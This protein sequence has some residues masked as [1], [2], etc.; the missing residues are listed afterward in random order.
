MLSSNEK[1]LREKFYNAV[2]ERDYKKQALIL[3]SFGDKRL[4][5]AISLDYDI[6]LYLKHH[7]F[8]KSSSLYNAALIRISKYNQSLKNWQEKSLCFVIEAAIKSRI[9]LVEQVFLESIS[10]KVS[11]DSNFL[12]LIEKDKNH[13]IK[14]RE[15]AKEGIRKLDENNPYNLMNELDAE[16]DNSNSKHKLLRA[17]I[18][19]REVKRAEQIREIYLTSTNDMKGLIKELLSE[20]ITLLSIPPCSYAILGLGSLARSEMTPYSDLEFAIIVEDQLPILME[21]GK[22]NYKI[23]G[24]KYN[25]QNKVYFRNLATL[26]HLKIINLGETSLGVIGED[27]LEI[28]YKEQFRDYDELACGFCFDGQFAR[29]CRTPLGN[30]HIFASP[31]IGTSSKENK[32]TF[33]LIGTIDEFQNFQGNKWKK[34]DK[35]LVLELANIE[36]L[37]GSKELFDKYKKKISTSSYIELR[38]QISDFLLNEDLEK[39]KSKIEGVY[40][41]K[42]YEIKKEIYRLPDRIIENLSLL[43]G[44]NNLGAWDRINRLVPAVF[45]DVAADNLKVILGISMELRL[46]VY[47]HYNKRAEKTTIIA[48]TS[49]EIDYKDITSNH[50][51]YIFSIPA[52]SNKFNLQILFRFYYTIF[53]LQ[54]EIE[55][56]KSNNQV[57]IK[58]NLY[59]N[60]LWIKSRILA[61]LLRYQE[62]IKLLELE[63]EQD[64]KFIKEEKKNKGYL[65]NWKIDDFNSK[66]GQLTNWCMM[67][68][69][70]KK[71]EH[72]KDLLFGIMNSGTM[73]I[74]P[75]NEKALLQINQVNEINSYNSAVAL[76]AKGYENFAYGNCVQALESFQH[77]LK[78]YAQLD[79]KQE[80]IEVKGNIVCLYLKQHEIT[81]S[82]EFIY[83]AK[84][85]LQETFQ[86]LS[87]LDIQNE[88]NK[89]LK[90]LLKYQNNL[91]NFC[92][93]KNHHAT[94]EELVEII[95]EEQNYYP[96]GHPTIIRMQMQL[97]LILINI[98]IKEAIKT[99]QRLLPITKKMY[100]IEAH[101]DVVNVLSSLGNIYIELQFFDLAIKNLEEAQVIS[102]K[103]LMPDLTI[104]VSRDLIR[105]ILMKGHVLLLKNE[106]KALDS[107]AIKIY[108]KA[109]FIYNKSIKKEEIK[110]TICSS[111]F[112][113][114]A[115]SAYSN[116]KLDEALNH[117]KAV[118]KIC[119]N[120]EQFK[121][122]LDQLEKIKSIEAKLLKQYAKN[123]NLNI[124]KFNMYS[125]Q[126]NIKKYFQDFF[127]EL[128]VLSTDNDG[129]WQIE[130]SESLKYKL[131]IRG[132]MLSQLKISQSLT[133]SNIA[134]TMDYNEVTKEEEPDVPKDYTYKAS[135]EKRAKA[136]EG[137]YSND[138]V[139]ILIDALLKQN[140][141]ERENS[142]SNGNQDIVKNNEENLYTMILAPILN[143]EDQNVIASL[144]SDINRAIDKK[145]QQILVAIN[146][147]NF[148]WFTAQLLITYSDVKPHVQVILHDSAHHRTSL[149]IIEKLKEFPNISFSI[150]QEEGT[151][152]KIQV[153]QNGELI[154][155]YC[156]G[157]T[158]RLIANLVTNPNERGKW[159]WNC[160]ENNDSLLRNDDRDTVQKQ[161]P[162]R[163]GRFGTPIHDIALKLPEKVS[164]ELKLIWQEIIKNLD[165]PSKLFWKE[166]CSDTYEEKANKA[167]AIRGFFKGRI[168][169]YQKY[170]SF[171]VQFFKE[172]L[173]FQDNA[174]D[175]L[176]SLTT[177]D[178]TNVNNISSSSSN[179]DIG[180]ELTTAE[181]KNTLL[182][183][184][185]PTMDNSINTESEETSNTL[186]RYIEAKNAFNKLLIKY[187]KIPKKLKSKKSNIRKKELT[188]LNENFLKLLEK[189][190][191]LQ[192]SDH[193]HLA[194]GKNKLEL[195]LF[196]LKQKLKPDLVA[197]STYLPT[198]EEV[199]TIAFDEELSDKKIDKTDELDKKESYT[200][201]SDVDKIMEYYHSL[202]SRSSTLEQKYSNYVHEENYLEQAKILIKFGDREQEKATN[203]NY[204][205]QP[206]LKYHSVAKSASL[207]NS[208]LIRINKYAQQEEYSKRVRSKISLVEQRFLEGIGIDKK[209]IQ[210]NHSS[211]LT[212]LQKSKNFLDKIRKKAKED[213]DGLDNYNPYNSMLE[214]NNIKEENAREICKEKIQGIERARSISIKNLYADITI[215]MKLFVKALFRECVAVLGDPP[216]SY[217]VLGLGSMA[218]N[219]MTPYSDL[220]WAI[221]IEDK[222]GQKYN[223]ICGRGAEESKGEKREKYEQATEQEIIAVRNEQEHNKQYFRN[224]VTLL[225]IKIINLGETPLG[226]I[227]EE[228]LEK[229]YKEKF[230]DYDE[231]ACGFCFDGQFA[232]ACRTPLG[233]LH[234]DGISSEIEPFELIGTI[235]ELSDLQE[236]EWQ[237]LQNEKSKQS[238]NNKLL[239]LELANA[240]LLH[241]S[242][243]LFNQYK[244]MISTATYFN[245]RAEIGSALLKEDIEKYRLKTV[246][247][248]REGKLYEVKKEIYRLLDRTVENLALYKKLDLK[249]LSAWD[250]I[251]NLLSFNEIASQSL[252]VAL[253]I[254]MELRLRVYQSYGK[255]EESVVI[256]SDSNNIS[257]EDEA[258][259]EF[260]ISDKGNSINIQIL[261]RYYY[262]VLPFQ[263]IIDQILQNS[264]TIEQV[265]QNLQAG[266]LRSLYNDD[267]V[268]KGFVFN[269][270]ARYQE[271]S[272]LLEEACNKTEFGIYDFQE[273]INVLGRIYKK[274]GMRKKA[275]DL[276]SKS[277]DFDM[278]NDL[279]TEISNVITSREHSTLQLITFSDIGNIYV[280]QKKY[281]EAITIYAAVLEKITDKPFERGVTLNA[282]ADVYAETGRFQHALEKYNVAL[283]TFKK[284][285][286]L[287]SEAL[288]YNAIGNLY[289]RQ[290]NF[291][292]A[293][294]NYDKALKIFDSLYKPYS[295]IYTLN[296]IGHISMKYSFS[297]ASQ[298][299][300]KALK[301]SIKY[302]LKRSEAINY[303][304]IGNLY[305]KAKDI[306]YHFTRALKHYKDALAIFKDFKFREYEAKVELAI[307][308]L[309]ANAKGQDYN[310]NEALENYEKA[311]G[312]FDEAYYQESRARTLLA[313]GDLYAN[314]K[315]QS[316]N[317][318]K[319]LENYKKAL[320]FF[321]EVYYQESRAR[322]L[323]AIGDL[324]AN[325]KGPDYFNNAL[326]NYIQSST[327]YE[328]VKSSYLYKSLDAILN[329]IKN[330][331]DKSY[332]KNI[333]YSCT[334]EKQKIY[335]NL[336]E[337]F[338]KFQLS[339]N[340]NS[341]KY[342]DVDNTVLAILI[343]IGVENEIQNWSKKIIGKLKYCN[344]K[345]SLK[346]VLHSFICTHTGNSKNPYLLFGE[347]LGLENK[348]QESIKLYI[349]ASEHSIKRAGAFPIK[350]KEIAIEYWL[351]YNEIVL[352]NLLK[353]RLNLVLQVQQREEHHAIKILKSETF[354]YSSYDGFIH[355]ELIFLVKNILVLYKEELNTKN[356]L[357]PILIPKGVLVYHWVGVI[358]SKNDNTITISY[359]DSENQQTPLIWQN[360]LLEELQKLLRKSKI[361]FRQQELEV[362]RYNNCGPELIE[363]FVY[364]LTGT[365]ATQDGA[366]YLQSLLY[367]NSLLNTEIS[368]PQIEE[369]N[370][371]ITQLSN[372]VMPLY[373][374]SNIESIPALRIK[375]SYKLSMMISDNYEL[376]SIEDKNNFDIYNSN[377]IKPGFINIP[378][379]MNNPFVLALNLQNYFASSIT[380]LK[381]SA[382]NYLNNA[383]YISVR[384]VSHITEM[385]YAFVSSLLRDGDIIHQLR[386]L[387]NNE[388]LAEFFN[389]LH[390]CTD[391]LSKIISIAKNVLPESI[392]QKNILDFSDEELEQISS[393]LTDPEQIYTVMRFKTSREIFGDINEF[394]ENILK[395]TID[396]KIQ[397]ILKRFVHSLKSI[398]VVTDIIKYITQPTNTNLISL[399][400]DVLVLSSYLLSNKYLSLTTP[401]TAIPSIWYAFQ[402]EQ[403]MS[404]GVKV[405][406]SFSNF[407]IQE[408]DVLGIYAMPLYFGLNGVTIFYDLYNQK[409][410]EAA[411][412]AAGLVMMSVVPT[413]TAITYAV[414][415]TSQNIYSLYQLHQAI[416]KET[417]EN[418]AKL[419]NYVIAT[420]SKNNDIQEF[421]W[422]KSLKKNLFS[423][424][425]C[426]AWNEAHRE[427]LGDNLPELA[428][429]ELIVNNII[430]DLSE[431]SEFVVGSSIKYNKYNNYYNL[432][433]HKPIVRDGSIFIDALDEGVDTTFDHKHKEKYKIDKMLLEKL[434]NS[435]LDNLDYSNLL[436]FKT[437]GVDA[438]QL[439]GYVIDNNGNLVGYEYAESD[440]LKICGE[441]IIINENVEEDL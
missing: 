247:N 150:S 100:G 138:D 409:Y 96:N 116:R 2:I 178:T 38:K 316:Y 69:D 337:K 330:F 221:I 341:K 199:Y 197:Q 290:N 268:I 284:F 99:Y 159:I 369:N 98:D 320:G 334:E 282:I 214:L 35:L 204:K 427:S 183:R 385:K 386:I 345:F 48:P 411:L 12:E 203:L 262:T 190:N 404:A 16:N 430:R 391:D 11:G 273:V 381:I 439:H 13:L 8:V 289:A 186:N 425:V 139:M 194:I 66:I 313:I 317:F 25:K 32:E 414:I 305:A 60:S 140:G 78:I 83:R 44:Y 257:F 147:L 101:S 228:W 71:A 255:R 121:N 107:D 10:I 55:I 310:F 366:V 85:E 407:V 97:A 438:C 248:S 436:V 14:I 318:T 122:E 281:E 424:E 39:F 125:T 95:K 54:D 132:N 168:D 347:A 90:L 260:K 111:M 387:M 331:Y 321:D 164:N 146:F 378:N 275:L 160:G 192:L 28:L 74:T 437:I 133:D 51:A 253:G 59:D 413:L 20:C 371:M 75:K 188:K 299:Y 324:Y 131:Y 397:F 398:D 240:N 250:R 319:A 232:R 344:N 72:Y 244:G 400:H 120:N 218:R 179:N 279:D 338:K 30:M 127:G 87:K 314:A 343:R 141:K 166:L 276:Y 362:Q 82:I 163:A 223:E 88:K 106:D 93:G 263:K 335:T 154:N 293:K 27:W 216:C 410:A 416:L 110:N 215:K 26:F 77:A 23:E 384:F 374:I 29:A 52:F 418:F 19:T 322:T 238:Q 224:L 124:Y 84:Q 227:G 134:V 342:F 364:Y 129:N 114:M 198:L 286:K 380:I 401:L 126:K 45:N 5:E 367:E 136:V 157:Y 415:Y 296:S 285:G 408:K 220:E 355:N 333:V 142:N 4:E 370:R 264:Q 24:K 34:N 102:K 50:A 297:L 206:H 432:H 211:Y 195:I 41:G 89:L 128:P 222:A 153:S 151:L 261:F 406:H 252:K 43:N 108:Q 379:N 402:Q 353:L 363:N 435:K 135:E 202:S 428:D 329:C 176:C 236:R 103:L 243:E 182:H 376:S 395:Q 304:S 272:K 201:K 434:S 212:K 421:I 177:N 113:S 92:E 375:S 440:D 389:V 372:R 171:F 31:Y 9:F 15:K 180:K 7:Y 208:A 137:F 298:E 185:P 307:G 332:D 184:T 79:C 213:I 352:E 419:L 292:E 63:I 73:L 303:I 144:V 294:K 251:E 58:Q 173:E 326:E 360:A 109:A 80:I 249:F 311:L 308:K 350:S 339:F 377:N 175:L 328:K 403:Y 115:E 235:H 392:I 105:A 433:L 259:N 354:Y 365:R 336:I 270:L 119:P 256:V 189:F 76:N 64:L 315:G 431:V 301:I 412:Q 229:L 148:H 269:K 239:I 340:E 123:I 346:I 191:D 36:F 280:E 361:V 327:D 1:E 245:K 200:S 149:E 429:N 359:L 405:M 18:K 351:N 358:I 196:N 210:D 112:I 217:A 383:Q 309:Y 246:G 143:S 156:G 130:I 3:V 86:I 368:V 172:N 40:E 274:F 357:L 104:S 162:E 417:Q 300:D 62:A 306:N 91:L 234:Y 373:R 287:D 399:G 325:A 225:H 118:K 441:H 42:L 219:E 61:K 388:Q 230:G 22:E 266:N 174:I 145:V 390:K 348:D 165:E 231:L 288:T 6:N 233:N 271:A 254:S 49:T 170:N 169:I 17:E 302:N 152:P 155:L 423:N 349:E 46:R 21:L 396:N 241:G 312:F 295:K 94:K 67:V 283:E 33:E 187:N 68:N 278:K 258:R 161:L 394:K 47:L 291:T 422:Q 53:P 265:L 57:Q 426:K 158:A 209:I 277:L 267:L 181:L 226:V 65:T 70:Y 167:N 37:S 237:D 393:L 117:F 420:E 356:L 193:Q 382:S 56:F 81:N 207:Y 205:A 323:L 242:I